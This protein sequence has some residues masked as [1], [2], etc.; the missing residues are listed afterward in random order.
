MHN[1]CQIPPQLTGPPQLQLVGVGI[2][3]VFPKE[4][5]TY[6]WQPMQHIDGNMEPTFSFYWREWPYMFGNCVEGVSQVSGSCL[7]SVLRVSG[8]FLKSV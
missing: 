1:I 3:F 5:S 4:E 6:P 8:G 2:D 7:V